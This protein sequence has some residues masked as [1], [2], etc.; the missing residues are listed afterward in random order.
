MEKYGE[1]TYRQT[2]GKQVCKKP[3]TIN[4]FTKDT[5]NNGALQHTNKT[6]QKWAVSRL[7]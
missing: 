4:V 5:Q 3:K 6:K 7:D 2:E 1:M